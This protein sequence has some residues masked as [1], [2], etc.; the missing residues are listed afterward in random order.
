MFFM[1][2][3]LDFIETL[4]ADDVKAVIIA[5]I[6]QYPQ[7][8]KGYAL[9]LFKQVAAREQR[10][11]NGKS[12]PGVAGAPIGNQ[13]AKKKEAVENNQKQSTID[14][15]DSESIKNNRETIETIPITN[16]NTNTN[17]NTVPIPKPKT[18]PKRDTI[19]AESDKSA[20]RSLPDD[21]PYVIGFP[22]NDGTPHKVR[23]SEIKRY[24]ELY[25]AVDVLQ[26][27]RN[28]AGWVEANPTKR[29]TKRG[30]H[31]F[32]NSWLA[33]C[34]D[35]GGNNNYHQRSNSINKKTLTELF[36][37]RE[38]ENNGKTGS[39]EATGEVW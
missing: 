22:L 29:K 9:V 4:P 39:Y 21:E 7:E 26:E 20:P 6:R 8:L 27:L 1:I 11:K 30:V 34:Q 38:A 36:D 18:K 32:I 5:M 17:T 31:K 28:I 24:E 25:P 37:E 12:H 10:I 15:I 13:N 35:K 33:R 19:C 23:Q 16:T 3:D 2:E 14:L